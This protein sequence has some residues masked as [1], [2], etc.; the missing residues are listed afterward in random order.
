[1]SSLVG[2]YIRLM[3]NTTNESKNGKAEKL[4]YQ[5]NQNKKNLKFDPM[6]SG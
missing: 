1:M 6:G 5:L 4:N 3:K 2:Y